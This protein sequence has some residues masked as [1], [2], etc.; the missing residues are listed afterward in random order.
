MKAGL[1]VAAAARAFNIEGDFVDA[2]P[3]GS[4]HI[5]DTYCAVFQS[6]GARARFVLQRINHHIFKDP[7]TLMDNIQ[8]VTAHLGA[9]VEDQPDRHRRVL[10]LIPSRDGRALHVDATGNYWRMYRFIEDARTV[11]AVESADQ[12]FE[13]AKAFGEFQKGLAI[14]PASASARYDPRLSS[15]PQ[16]LRRA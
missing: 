6:Q 4:G 9:Q 14:A 12:A 13:A 2:Q 15:H 10:T 16:T 3:Y 7:V 5:N 8:R 1:D 11:D